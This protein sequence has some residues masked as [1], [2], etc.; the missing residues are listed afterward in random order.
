MRDGC[1]ELDRRLSGTLLCALCVLAVGKNFLPPRRKER[2]ENKG[3]ILTMEHFGRWMF[4]GLA[5][6]SLI[7]SL[8]TTAVWIR[9]ES[10]TD[11]WTVHS[12]YRAIAELRLSAGRLSL[13]VLNVR[14]PTD[15]SGSWLHWRYWD[16]DAGPTDPN[17]ADLRAWFAS[18]HERLSMGLPY[19]VGRYELMIPTLLIVAVMC[20]FPLLWFA[21][22]IRGRDGRNSGLCGL[23]GYDLRVTPGRCPECGTVT[24]GRVT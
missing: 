1:D 10:I 17:D 6:L 22:R 13:V 18:K 4:N 8:A 12:P 15:N 11:R 23:C 7:V 19:P 9:S 21:A 3:T 24:A 20:V 5:I 14:D 16:H 2:Q